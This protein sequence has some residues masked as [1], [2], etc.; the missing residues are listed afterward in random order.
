MGGGGITREMN[1]GSEA[2]TQKHNLIILSLVR[3]EYTLT[4]TSV[5]QLVG[6]HPTKRKVAGS[7]PGQGTCLGCRFSLQ[8]GCRRNNR[9]MF[10]SYID[11]SLPLFLPPFLSLSK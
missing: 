4:L 11:V 8:S 10:F 5:A 1:K 7:I 2:G 6:R 3:L 9:L